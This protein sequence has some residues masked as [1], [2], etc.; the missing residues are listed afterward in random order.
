MASFDAS[1]LQDGAFGVV[2]IFGFLQA[3]KSKRMNRFSILDK[4]FIEHL[5]RFS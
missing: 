1:V 2:V 5:I 4:C 3:A